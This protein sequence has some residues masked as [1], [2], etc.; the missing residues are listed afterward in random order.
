MHRQQNRLS[1]ALCL[2]L[3]VA[4][5][6]ALQ[7]PASLFAGGG[8]PPVTLSLVPSSRTVQPG[9]TLTFDVALQM[10]EN[11]HAISTMSLI[12]NFDPQIL[13]A[14]AMVPGEGLSFA[15]QLPPQ[16]GVLRPKNWTVRYVR[17]LPSGG[18]DEDQP[19]QRRADHQDP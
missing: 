19:V 3:L 6:S 12:W 18:P 15:E 8:Q 5:A 14:T 10:V 17:I 13:E 7:R 16:A 1:I 11:S 2:L 9:D 4:M